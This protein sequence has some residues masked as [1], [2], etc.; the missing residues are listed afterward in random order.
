MIFSYHF[1]TKY[2]TTTPIRKSRT[3]NALSIPLNSD[4]MFFSVTVT[5]ITKKSKKK[6][7]NK[8]PKQKQIIDAFDIKVHVYVSGY[9]R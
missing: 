4:I 2:V 3:Q 5:F 9:E 7:Q 8:T 1:T 6:N